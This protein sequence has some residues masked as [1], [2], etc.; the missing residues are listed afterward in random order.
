MFFL[1]GSKYKAKWRDVTNKQQEYCLC[2]IDANVYAYL[3]SP[4]VLRCV[5][6]QDTL[7]PAWYWFKPGMP[8]PT[9]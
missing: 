1:Y 4:T 9:Y 8:V 5:L 3:S 6:E 7:I 2:L